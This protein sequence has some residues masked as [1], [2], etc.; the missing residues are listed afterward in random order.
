MSCA[1][2]ERRARL[3]GKADFRRVFERPER[4]ADGG[5][6]VLARPNG[7]GFARLGMAI[8]RKVAKSAVQ[9]NRIK[10]VVRESFR[11]NRHELGGIDIV[12][13]GRPDLGKQN[14]KTIFDALQRH[15]KRLTKR[16]ARS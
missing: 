8:S 12:V 1:R 11:V 13:I 7:L 15:W 4:S 5:F 9:R 10:R 6:T 16:C 14:N 2:F 3:A